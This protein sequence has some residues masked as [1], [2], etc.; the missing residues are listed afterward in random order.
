MM[1]AKRMLTFLLF[2]IVGTQILALPSE[3]QIKQF[4][5]WYK[6]Q[7]PWFSKDSV[8][9]IENLKYKAD[10]QNEKGDFWWLEDEETTIDD[11]E[12]EFVDID[13]STWD[14]DRITLGAT[15]ELQSR[16][17]VYATKPIKKGDI[18]L[19]IPKSLIVAFSDLLL[20]DFV[21]DLAHKLWMYYSLGTM[22][23]PGYYEAIHLWVLFEK[24]YAQNH[25]ES[26]SEPRNSWDVGF[27]K[28]WLDTLPEPSDMNNILFFKFAEL[29]ELIGSPLHKRAT[30]RRNEMKDHFDWLMD[31][32]IRA[33]P[34]VFKDEPSEEQYKWSVSITRSTNFQVKIPER[35]D[36]YSLQPAIVPFLDKFRHVPSG[37]QN[38]KYFYDIE[39]KQFIVQAVA[40]VN[41]GEELT[42][43]WGPKCNSEL[44]DF[45]GFILDNNP[46]DCVH[47]NL[48][49]NS[50][51]PMYNS[52]NVLLKAEKLD[53]ADYK[54][55]RGGLTS[56]L[57]LATRIMTLDP[58]DWRLD[59]VFGGFPRAS[60]GTHA[61]LAVADFLLKQCRKQYTA[62]PTSI[63]E[64]DEAMNE[65][66]ISP[67]KRLA[68]LVRKG[69]KDILRTMGSFYFEELK[70]LADVLKEEIDEGLHDE[71]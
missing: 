59:F 16:P 70:R 49:L 47:V 12:T 53:P 45:H 11:T 66:G 51:D 41:P 65:E 13:W 25:P 40:D 18:I 10:L 26:A 3:D 17:G 37:H 14:R 54:L 24:F 57:L 69:E 15:S 8:V 1:G 42:V 31:N 36:A 56:E 9:D 6:T 34:R 67:R 22:F 62:Y 28:L 5:N 55:V 30:D 2:C 63:D 29:R 4:E 68:I 20:H 61:D 50:G 32:V 43:S 38:V 60:L 7:N 35:K 23:D 58:S 64:D 44:L 71:L 33:Y 39:D 52:K 46:D 19:T 21:G 27:W 48:E